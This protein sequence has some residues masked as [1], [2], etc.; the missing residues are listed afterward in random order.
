ML[1]FAHY[2]ISKANCIMFFKPVFSL[3]KFFHT[4]IYIYCIAAA[5]PAS[6]QQHYY[7][8]K[9]AV[10]K[11]P[12][13][14]NIAGIRVLSLRYADTLAHITQQFEHWRYN[15]ADTLANPYYFP[16]FISGN[17][18]NLPSGRAFSLNTNGS[19]DVDDASIM[20]PVANRLNASAQLLTEAYVAAPWLMQTDIDATEGIDTETIGKKLKNEAAP[21][22]KLTEHM[23]TPD[24]D[25]KP[26][27]TDADIVIKKPNFWTLKSNVSLQFTQY[28]VSENWYKGGEKNYTMLANA[29]FEANFNNKRKLQFDNKLEMKLGFQTSESDEEHKF[30][31][32][33]DQIRL[34]N[35]L[36]LKAIKNWSYTL[37]L[38]SWTQFYQGYKKNDTKVYSDFMSP[39]ESIVSLG[40]DY[41][42]SK[43]KAS[44]SATLSPIAINVKYCDR[45]AIVGRFGIEQGKHHKSTFGSTVTV[46]GNVKFC[47]AISWS[48]RYYAFYDYKHLKMEWE[49]TIN[50][51]VNK[52]LSTKLF[53]YPRF[54]NSVTKKEGHK[55]YVQ[56]NEQL[57]ISL[58][59]SF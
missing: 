36:G 4:I 41:K 9:H 23:Q 26:E 2:I 37:S 59:L 54:D 38:Q 39:F 3:R 7:G 43:K 57:S 16:V 51:R 45:S 42:L 44:L 14:N 15:G 1:K 55:S 10:K 34:T 52:Y 53:L 50:L 20:T 8:N 22:L 32:T 35:Q 25:D 17:L 46:N 18:Q 27:V 19:F 49:N 6:A 58:N 5:L 12:A 47:D 48:W 29:V 30:K 40:M 31:T 56:F 33:A 13:A 21:K 11:D 28:H 24:E